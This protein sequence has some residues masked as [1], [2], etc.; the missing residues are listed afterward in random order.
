MAKLKLKETIGAYLL[1]NIHNNITICDVT[2]CLKTDVLVSRYLSFYLSYH[3]LY[4][5][6][7]FG[8]LM[9]SVDLRSQGR[10]TAPANLNPLPAACC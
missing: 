10:C 4:E 5:G 3:Y 1:Q 8:F 6:S 7:H 9:K 2:L